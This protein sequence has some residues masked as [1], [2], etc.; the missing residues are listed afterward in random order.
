MYHSCQA[1]ILCP[2]LHSFKQWC[3]LIPLPPQQVHNR[4]GRIESVWGGYH[5][6]QTVCEKTGYISV[7]CYKNGV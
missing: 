3:P 4:A 6:T 7:C 2:R 1:D 5:L